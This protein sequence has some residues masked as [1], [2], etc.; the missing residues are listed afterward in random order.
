[1]PG[2][3][4]LSIACSRATVERVGPLCVTWVA[5]PR[6]TAPSAP[7]TSVLRMELAVESVTVPTPTRRGADGAATTATRPM[8]A[9]LLAAMKL[10]PPKLQ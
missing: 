9:A 10:K 6:R 1:M 5:S 8:P 2:A 3:S 7:P 4:N